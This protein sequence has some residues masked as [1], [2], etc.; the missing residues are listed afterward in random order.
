MGPTCIEDDKK[1]FNRHS[2]FEVI[3]V[4]GPLQ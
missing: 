4:P 2:D 3:H 1:F